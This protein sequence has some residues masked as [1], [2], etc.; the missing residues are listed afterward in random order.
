[1]MLD[2][3]NGL[4]GN[5]EKESGKDGV[6]NDSGKNQKPGNDDTEENPSIVFPYTLDEKGL[7]IQSIEGYNGLFIEDGSDYEVENIAAMIITNQGETNIEYAE[8]KVLSEARTLNFAIT[9]LPAGETL[10]VQES[11]GA[12]FAEEKYKEVECNLAPIDV[13]QMS[14]NEISIVDNKDHS[15]DVTNL[16]DKTIPCVRVFYKF[17]MEEEDV[18]VGGITYTAKLTELEAG[19]TCTITPTHY[20]SGSSKVVMVRTY[21]TAE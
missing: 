3:W 16:T 7:V 10:V 12:E 1:M 21:E 20:V 11:T 15:L 18:Y 2:G 8:I 5:G 17:Y 9:T 13:F 19:E 14:E 4:I 6:S